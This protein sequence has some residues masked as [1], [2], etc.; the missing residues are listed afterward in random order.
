MN[1]RYLGPLQQ[2]INYRN[3]L[4]STY[5]LQIPHPNGKYL[6]IRLITQE[7]PKLIAESVRKAGC[8]LGTS[9]EAIEHSITLS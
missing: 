5:Y 2:N 6:K 9:E 8:G 1:F 3:L 7:L 4:K